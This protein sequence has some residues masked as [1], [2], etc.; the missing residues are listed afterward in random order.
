MT[1]PPSDDKGR[2]DWTSQLG[3]MSTPQK[4]AYG[5]SII[6][7]YQDTAKV[8][9]DAKAITSFGSSDDIV[10]AAKKSVAASVVAANIGYSIAGIATAISSIPDNGITTHYLYPFSMNDKLSSSSKLEAHIASVVSMIKSSWNENIKSIWRAQLGNLGRLKGIQLQLETI[11]VNL[12]SRSG[13]SEVISRFLNMP[14]L[15]LTNATSIRNQIS[16]LSNSNLSMAITQVS[17]LGQI[18]SIKSMIDSNSSFA[19]VVYDQLTP[20]ALDQQISSII[21]NFKSTTDVQTLNTLSG[22]LGNLVQLKSIYSSMDFTSGVDYAKLVRSF[23]AAVPPESLASQIS[24]VANNTPGG[25]YDHINLLGQVYVGDCIAP[26]SAWYVVPV[27]SGNV[28]GQISTINS[29]INDTNRSVLQPQIDILTAISA[30]QDK[31]SVYKMSISS[32]ED[33]IELLSRI[34]KLPEVSQS[35][36]DAIN[37]LANTSTDATLKSA[38]AK[39]IQILQEIMDIKHAL[40]KST[41][42]SYMPPVLVEQ[43]KS[44][45]EAKS[46]AINAAN[47]AKALL[48]RAT[49]SQYAVDKARQTIDIARSS[50]DKA[51]S[52]INTSAILFDLASAAAILP[53]AMRS[54]QRSLILASAGNPPT[55]L[56]QEVASLRNAIDATNRINYNI[57]ATRL[58]QNLATTCNAILQYN[59]EQIFS[60]NPSLSYYIS[61]GNMLDDMAF[62]AYQGLFKSFAEQIKKDANSISDSLKEVNQGQ[63]NVWLINDVAPPSFNSQD[64]FLFKMPLFGDITVPKLMVALTI[65]LGVAWLVFF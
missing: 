55:S 10:N 40:S 43:L 49:V 5:K 18:A 46:N 59:L 33:E 24:S 27:L 41:A 60:G 30:I 32:L 28:S 21:G 31:F 62:N 61:I 53:M 63:A 37:S 57:A 11:G 23:L 51:L 38:L 48:D 22:H 52:I 44:I 14:N 50:A 8:I 1:S 56:A 9:D 64:I 6:L 65:A 42:P 3:R 54:I 47:A 36:I 16:A 17:I 13:Q 29:K 12:A 7:Q 25:T 20:E 19:D 4:E 2:D 39:Q 15:Q 26:D 58:A 34:E 35:Q 45:P